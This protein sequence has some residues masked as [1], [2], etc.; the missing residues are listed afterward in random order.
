MRSRSPARSPSGWVQ[1]WGRALRCCAAALQGP[2]WPVRFLLP[3]HPAAQEHCRGCAATGEQMP[4]AA[5]AHRRR[6]RRASRRRSQ[7]RRPTSRRA[8]RPWRALGCPAWRPLARS[9]V[10]RRSWRRRGT[11]G[12]R[13]M[14]SWTAW[15]LALVGP[16]L[17]LGRRPPL[18]T[19]RKVS[20]AAGGTGVARA[21]WACQQPA[22]AAGA[23]PQRWP[24]QASPWGGFDT[25]CC[26]PSLQWPT[27]TARPPTPCG[28]AQGVPP[29]CA[30]S[31]LPWLQAR[32]LQRRCQPQQQQR[33]HLAPRTRCTRKLSPSHQYPG[34]RC[35]ACGW[36][37]LRRRQ[38]QQQQQQQRRRRWQQQQGP[39]RERQKRPQREQQEQVQQLCLPAWA[40]WMHP[41]SPCLIA[42]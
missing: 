16:Q 27:S 4:T 10:G 25:K 35:P 12:T 9:Q 17:A 18:P 6:R 37:Q 2:S 34:K 41:H 7:T 20:A 3:G 1:P 5:R 38:Q 40:T 13:A 36:R 39:P 19:R 30:P 22:G 15:A 24:Q 21:P 28:W 31:R 42:S 26:A 33:C 14:C 23:A 8:P 11:W 32:L 29:P